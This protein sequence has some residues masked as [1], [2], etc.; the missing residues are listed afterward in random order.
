VIELVTTP[1][2]RD[3]VVH[4]VASA[5]AGAVVT[6]DGIVRNHARGKPVTHLYY[7]AYP[8][9]AKTEMAKIREQALKRWPLHGLSIVHRTGRLG[10]GESSVFIAV[11]SAH[12]ADGFEAC[13]FVIDTLKTSVPIWKKEHYEDGEV[14]I[15]GYGA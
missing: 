8:E 3:Q 2:D 14:W 10:I 11:A 4:S 15:E 1:I 5:K 9:M 12:R 7:E 6:F 13:R